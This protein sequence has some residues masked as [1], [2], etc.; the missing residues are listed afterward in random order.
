MYKV[1]TMSLYSFLGKEQIEE[2]E[3]Y[4]FA[5]AVMEWIE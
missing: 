2:N 1:I 4:N 5:T 3:K